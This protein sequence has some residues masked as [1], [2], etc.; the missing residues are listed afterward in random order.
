MQTVANGVLIH[1]LLP[2]NVSKRFSFVVKLRC[3]LKRFQLNIHQVV[4]YTISERG[5]R[6]QLWSNTISAVDTTLPFT[7]VLNVRLFPLLPNTTCVSYENWCIR[8]PK[9]GLVVV[10][11]VVPK[12]K[13]AGNLVFI[14]PTFSTPVTNQLY[15]S[16]NFYLE[17]ATYVDHHHIL[18]HPPRNM[19]REY[20]RRYFLLQESTF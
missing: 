3:I 13:L 4:T 8:F 5:L 16:W 9:I 18:G 19:S 11:T 10:S 20:L 2:I 7:T 1:L 15:F 6:H 12:S 17:E 14:T